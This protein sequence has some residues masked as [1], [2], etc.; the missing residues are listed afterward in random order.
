MPAHEINHDPT[1]VRLFK[2]DFLEFFT[3][4]SPVT[5]VVIWVPVIGWLLWSTISKL[6]TAS[7][8]VIPAGLVIGL[9][10]WTLSEYTLHRF[11]FH[12]KPHGPFQE[13]LSFLFHGVHH[14]QP[15]AKTRLVMPIALSIPL[16]SLFFL[17]FWLIVGK[18]FN[19]PLWVGPLFA[20]FLIGYLVY[21][22]IH[23]A[24]HHFAM[25]TGY[26]KFI[27]R[28][29]MAHHYKNPAA[30]FGV[31]NPLWDYVFKTAIKV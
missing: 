27:K 8:W 14:Y 26:W 16:A 30:L 18:A 11:L 28:Y 4:I 23:Y 25:R 12:F 29:H 20:G 17:A 21:D 19:A 13:R 15:Q 2:S 3:H 24:T 7:W 22:L 1:P 6:S 31:S 10:L 5:I 9:F